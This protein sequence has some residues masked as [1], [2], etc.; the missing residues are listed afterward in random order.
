LQVFF[1]LA[2]CLFVVIF[3]LPIYSLSTD[4]QKGAI[5]KLETKKQKKIVEDL[6]DKRRKEGVKRERNEEESSGP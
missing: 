3:Y 2:Y 6:G 1:F 4:H 5:G